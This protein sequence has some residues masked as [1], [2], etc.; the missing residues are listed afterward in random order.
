MVLLCVHWQLPSD[1]PQGL[2]GDGAQLAFERLR[3]LSELHQLGVTA[4]TPDRVIAP[5]CVT[6]ARFPCM[7]MS[8]AFGYA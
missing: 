3:I 1:A 8:A 5:V 6:A 2:G 4:V 7:V